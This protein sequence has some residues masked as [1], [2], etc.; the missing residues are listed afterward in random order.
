MRIRPRPTSLPSNPIEAD[1][2]VRRVPGSRPFEV[3]AAA[4][5]AAIKSA[6][7]TPLERFQAGE[8]DREG[9][10][11]ALIHEATEHLRMLPASDQEMIQRHLRDVLTTEPF[12][13]LI[14]QATRDPR[15]GR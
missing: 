1:D 12:V 11:E 13:S 10:V 7:L 14:A 3:S 4:E 15:S 8:L 6:P 5:T 2:S 9:Y